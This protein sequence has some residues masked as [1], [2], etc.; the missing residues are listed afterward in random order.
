MTVAPANAFPV[1]ALGGSA[2][3]LAAFTAFFEA[4]EATPGP[5]NMAFVVISHLSPDHKSHLAELLQRKVRL[6]VLEVAA[7]TEIEAGHVYVIAP[8]QALVVRQGWLEPHRR[9]P[10]IAHPVDELFTSLGEDAGS[11]AIAIVMSG[12]GSNG[13]AGLSAV[14]EGGGLVLAQSPESAEFKEMPTRA[15][16]TGFVDSV[17]LPEEM[18]ATILHYAW[19]LPPP[20]IA[21]QREATKAE[22]EEE[23]NKENA[24]GAILGI[25]RANTSI[26]FRSYKTGTLQRRIARRIG[27]LR[28]E[29]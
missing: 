2:G 27:F 22:P 14:R 8:G 17:L 3:G 6:P 5:V 12:T 1:V 26:D 20:V 23:E 24:F 19:H 9:G 13:S 15:I 29:S 28:L 21:E 25:L 18:I 10:G 16:G 11:R 7:K 4:V